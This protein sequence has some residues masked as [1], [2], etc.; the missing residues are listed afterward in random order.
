MMIQ[1]N[2]SI[3]L[4]TSKGNA[5][6]HFLIDYGQEHHLEWVCFLE[7]N[8]ECWTFQNPDIRAQKNITQG[9]DKIS[10]IKKP[11]KSIAGQGIRNE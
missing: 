2:P 11:A 4:I 6:A 7:D 10:E 3:P 1:L 9:R 5:L 8:G